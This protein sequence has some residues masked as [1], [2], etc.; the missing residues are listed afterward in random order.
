MSQIKLRED[1]EVNL[2]EEFDSKYIYISDPMLISEPIALPFAYYPLIQAMIEGTKT[3]EEIAKEGIGKLMNL[4]DDKLFTLINNLVSLQMIDTATSRMAVENMQEYMNGNVRNSYCDS[5]SYPKEP[6][7]LNV[8]LEKILSKGKELT[9]ERIKAI[10]AP[11][12]DLR[13]EESWEVYANSFLALK[14]VEDVDTVILLGT[15]HYRS[16]AN[17]M[18]TKKDFVTPL[19]KAE[20][21][22]ELLAEIETN[23][24]ITYDDI[25]H[26]KEHSIEFHLVFLQ[27][28][29]SEKNIRIVPILTGSPASYINDKTT[30]D[31]D[32]QYN[33]TVEAIRNAIAKSGK[34][35]LILSSGDLSH[36]GRKF[37]DD[38]AA[39][40]EQIRVKHEDE[41]LIKK[42]ATGNKNAFFEEIN[43]AEDKNK[44]CGTAPFYS[45]LSLV[46]SESIISAGY[47]QWH[48]V[49]TESLVSFAGFVVV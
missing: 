44:I 30:P 48:E 33:A 36:V 39:A 28:I 7:E 21:D 46:D 25:A 16:T 37:G 18:F 43:A 9:K 4:S 26:Y 29:L 1:L 13:L 6:T 19:G 12:I 49:E 35:V 47:N 38:F 3:A 27:H 17:F 24:E 5:F 40:T 8:F 14:N 15:S 41:L 32:E 20:V 23:T 31:S 10:L 2:I 11:H 22:Q 45:V 42:I 34:R